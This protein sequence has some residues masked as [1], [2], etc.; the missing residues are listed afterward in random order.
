MVTK[1]YFL[2]YDKIQ[3]SKKIKDTNP[4]DFYIRE[5]EWYKDQQIEI[6]T[7]QEVKLIHNKY[8][9]NYVELDDGMRFVSHII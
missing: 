2:P 6:I 5:E 9:N 3:L 4:E 8:R 7:G 1:D